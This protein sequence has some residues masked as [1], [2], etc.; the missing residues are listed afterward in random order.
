MRGLIKDFID[1]HKA[2][3]KYMF[4][5]LVL[6]DDSWYMGAEKLPFGAGWVNEFGYFK[7]YKSAIEARD[8]SE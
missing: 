7:T 1:E 8:S 5:C 3:L 4:F 6:T 2:R